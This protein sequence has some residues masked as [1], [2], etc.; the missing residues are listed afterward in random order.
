MKNCVQQ[1]HLRRLNE[2]LIVSRIPRIQAPEENQ[3]KKT[4]RKPNPKKEEE[5][6]SEIWEENPPE[7]DP[8]SIRQLFLTIKLPLADRA[9]R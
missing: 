6:Y 3:K 1:R 5:I 9:A 2:W 4:G 7:E 8:I